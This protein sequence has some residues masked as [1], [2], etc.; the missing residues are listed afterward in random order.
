MPVHWQFDGK[1]CPR[2][3]LERN[4]SRRDTGASRQLS[5]GRPIAVAA[6]APDRLPRAWSA[7]GLRHDHFKL[8]EI[9]GSGGGI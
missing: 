2:P 1:T 3:A 9:I 6:A 7:A 8:I 5:A 4:V